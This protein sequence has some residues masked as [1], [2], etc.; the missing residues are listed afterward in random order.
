MNHCDCRLR[1]LNCDAV[2]VHTFVT[3]CYKEDCLWKLWLFLD[4]RK[5]CTGHD[6]TETSLAQWKRRKLTPDMKLACACPRGPTERDQNL[7]CDAPIARF[8]IRNWI[9]VFHDHTRHLG[10]IFSHGFRATAHLN[11]SKLH[12]AGAKQLKSDG[13]SPYMAWLS[14]VARIIRT[15]KLRWGLDQYGC[16]KRMTVIQNQ[17]E[18]RTRWMRNR[19][20]T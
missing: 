12:I 15:E 3:S 19:K 20:L 2:I 14:I 9:I 1:N 4:C 17:T 8:P 13:G 16:N 5:V 18:R 10:R 7:R 11:A 6:K